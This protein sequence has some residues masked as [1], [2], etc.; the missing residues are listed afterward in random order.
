MHLLTSN[1]VYVYKYIHSIKNYYFCHYPH[2][3]WEY[4]QLSNLEH[5]SQVNS[6][7]C[8]HRAS[9]HLLQY[10]YW[11]PI[12][13]VVSPA[14]SSTDGMPSLSSLRPLHGRLDAKTGT[15]TNGC[16][17]FSIKLAVQR[18]RRRLFWSQR[19]RS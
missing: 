18:T 7:H 13:C 1:M 8:Q 9:T 6:K 12:R 19:S 11:G 2:R 3:R 5:L 17:C 15:Q 16:A 14:T 4:S 10:N